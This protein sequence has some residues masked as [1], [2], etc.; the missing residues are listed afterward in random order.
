MNLVNENMIKLLSEAMVKTA[1]NTLI[2]S[3]KDGITIPYESKFKI[4]KDF[5]ES[6]WDK[7]D[8]EKVKIIMAENIEKQ[9][10]DKVTNKLATEISNDIKQLL[11]DKEKREEIRSY[12]RLLLKKWEN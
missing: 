2:N 4:P 8:K 1:T 3:L 7:V 11:S 12:A 9:I 10:A 5:F 6:V